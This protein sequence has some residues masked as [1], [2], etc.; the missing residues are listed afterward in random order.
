MTEEEELE[1]LFIKQRSQPVIYN[2]KNHIKT[3]LFEAC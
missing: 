3:K 1:K 2:I